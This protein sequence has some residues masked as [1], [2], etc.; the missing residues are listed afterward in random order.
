MKAQVLLIPLLS[1]LATGLGGIIAVASGRVSQGTVPLLLGLSSGIGFTVV[2]FDLLP[3]AVKIGNWISV[4]EGILTGFAFGVLTEKGFPYISMSGQNSTGC[5]I[6]RKVGGGLLKTGYMFALGTAM[7]NIPEGMAIGAGLEARTELG[8]LLAA[9]IG[10]H[11]IPEGMALCGVLIIGGKGVLRSLAYAFA[12]G[13]MLPVGT[14]FTS[15]WLT[16]SREML[17]F[18]LSFGAGTLLFI[19]IAELVPQ[20]LRMHSLRAKCGIGLGAAVSIIFSVVSVL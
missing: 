13:L 18:L 7:H 17:S 19:I 10:I 14:L 8:I 1:G 2:F 4:W 20:S 16:A 11:N 15:A 3:E 9:A 12:A 6:D 5:I